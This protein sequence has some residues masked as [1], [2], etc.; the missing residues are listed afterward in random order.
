MVA[1]APERL[2]FRFPL[3]RRVGDVTGEGVETSPIH[4]RELILRDMSVRATGGVEV[5][6]VAAPTQVVDQEPAE[7]LEPAGVGL[8]DGMT[9]RG[10]DRDL[11]ARPLSP[12]NA[13]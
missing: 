7:R 9:G 8:D 2:V 4:A 6:V 3:A 5:D 11:H 13:A 12:A 1:Q 10:D